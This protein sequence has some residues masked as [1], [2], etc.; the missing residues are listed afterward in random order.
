M[1]GAKLLNEPVK[2]SQPYNFGPY[3]ADAL[4][5]KAM[6]DLA[7][8]SWGK[9]EYEVQQL[10]NQ[11]HEAGLLKLDISKAIAE[12]GWKPKLDAE[13]AIK[14][15]IDWYKGFFEDE[16]HINNFTEKQIIDFLNS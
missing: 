6:V 2:Y 10:A 5:V 16:R 3:S 15:T 14:Y 9:G 4:P 7:I 11:P 12:I 13:K 8:T 1:L